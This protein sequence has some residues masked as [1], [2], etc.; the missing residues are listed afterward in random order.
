LASA[1]CETTPMKAKATVRLRFA[2]KEQLET[3]LNAIK[4]EAENQASRRA[5]TILEKEGNS[6]VLNVEADDTIALRASLNAYLRWTSAVLDV[7]E[8]LKTQTQENRFDRA[9]KC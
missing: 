8:V 9:R 1:L 6:L 4:P 7:L 3:V 2:A 5:R